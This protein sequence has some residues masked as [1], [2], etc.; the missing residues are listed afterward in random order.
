MCSALTIPVSFGL[1]FMVPLQ[2]IQ[3]GMMKALKS[4]SFFRTIRPMSRSYNRLWPTNL[5][6]STVFSTCNHKDGQ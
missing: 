1:G 5:F 4:T 6:G 3:A 2:S